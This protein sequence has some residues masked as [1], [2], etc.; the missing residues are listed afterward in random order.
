[1]LKYYN[2]SLVPIAIFSSN[3]FFSIAEPEGGG[4][5]PLIFQRSLGLSLI[6][7]VLCVRKVPDSIKHRVICYRVLPIDSLALHGWIQYSINQ[8]QEPLLVLLPGEVPCNVPYL[9]IDGLIA[10]FT[11]HE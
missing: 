4:I 2:F 1:M 5:K 6:Y 8:I 11:A 9:K 7:S 3:H 10:L